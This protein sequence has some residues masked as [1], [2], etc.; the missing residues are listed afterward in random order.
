MADNIMRKVVIDKL[1]LSCG[2]KDEKLEKSMKLLKF[3]TGKNPI[4]ATTKKRIAAFALRPNLPIGCK[5][6]LRGNQ[7]ME[8]LPKFLIVK[9]N[10]LKRKQV[11]QGVVNF[12]INEYIEIPGMQ[13]QREIGIL[14]FD[15]SLVLK[16]AG[17]NTPLRKIKTGRVPLRHKIT[18]E[19]TIKFIQE[20]FGTKIIEKK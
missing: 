2:A 14:G 5:V 16:R 19:E 11:G 18:Q 9:T 3:L 12:G 8:I 6:T 17:F 10:T 4:K 20:K 15:V 13:F 7:I 1:V